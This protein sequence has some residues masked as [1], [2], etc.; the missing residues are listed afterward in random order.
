MVVPRQSTRQPPDGYQRYPVPQPRPAL[1]NVGGYRGRNFITVNTTLPSN[2]RLVDRSRLPNGHTAADYNQLFSRLPIELEGALRSRGHAE[3]TVTIDERGQVVPHDSR[4]RNA[5]HATYVSAMIRR[6]PDGTNELVGI[7]GGRSGGG[8]NG[9]PAAMVTSKLMSTPAGRA[10]LANCPVLDAATFDWG[11]TQLANTG[12]LNRD[13]HGWEFADG[14]QTT[15]TPYTQNQ[16]HGVRRQT[17]LG[18]HYS[19]HDTW[20]CLS[21]TEESFRARLN[22][23]IAIM[24][25]TNPPNLHDWG[26]GLGLQNTPRVAAESFVRNR[27]LAASTLGRIYHLNPLMFDTG[28]PRYHGLAQQLNVATGPMVAA[29]PHATQPM[30]RQHPIMQPTAA[31]T[32][33]GWVIPPAPAVQR[34]RSQA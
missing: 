4:S 17:A 14:G 31:A 28:N 1:L 19:R 15:F 33:G 30:A 23:R 7:W 26:S 5:P 3:V 20:G 6:K 9:A 34:P 16:T 27:E 24:M 13:P 12:T 2:P 25:G 8:N 11:R 22:S 21:G 29:A 18:E 10:A 32:N